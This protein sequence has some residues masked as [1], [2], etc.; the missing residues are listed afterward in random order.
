MNLLQ[1]HGFYSKRFEMYDL[2]SYVAITKHLMCALSENCEFCFP[3]TLMQCFPETLGKQNTLFSSYHTFSVLY[4]CA[5][6]KFKMTHKISSYL[7][8]QLGSRICVLMV[9][10]RCTQNMAKIQILQQKTHTS[11]CFSNPGMWTQFNP[12]H[13][14]AVTLV[15][16]YI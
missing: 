14:D 11:I 4:I 3:S 9:R 1:R 10:K 12:S 6:L 7:N 13:L 16:K 15:R 2:F 8:K 5:L